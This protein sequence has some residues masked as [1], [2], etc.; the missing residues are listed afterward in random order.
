[1]NTNLKKAK[2]RS[3]DYFW[4]INMF[5]G[6]FLQLITISHLD[7]Y[8]DKPSVRSSSMEIH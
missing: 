8:V 1:L 7:V 3:D 5:M 6:D 4:G 2:S